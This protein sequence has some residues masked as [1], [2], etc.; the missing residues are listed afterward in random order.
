M[1]M[2]FSCILPVEVLLSKGGI[3]HTDGADLLCYYFSQQ[4]QSFLLQNTSG[5]EIEEKGKKNC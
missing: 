1:F 4:G 5:T 2:H 3:N